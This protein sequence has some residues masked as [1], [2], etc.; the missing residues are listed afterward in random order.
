MP[1]EA[2]A[3]RRWGAARWIGLSLILLLALLVLYVLSTGPVMAV[4]FKFEFFQHHKW[5]REAFALVYWPLN[6]MTNR[7]AAAEQF[8]MWYVGLWL[9]MFDVR[10]AV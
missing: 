7:S 5:V 6:E 8:F 3:E 10:L 4:L 2:D 1:D 9:E